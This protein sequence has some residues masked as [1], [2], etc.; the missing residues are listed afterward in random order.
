[1]GTDTYLGNCWWEVS[2]ATLS[3]L[4]VG[5]FIFPTPYFAIYLVPTANHIPN[6]TAEV[7][8]MILTPFSEICSY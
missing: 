4:L 6:W 8:V 1:M 2:H 3:A 7:T 5:C